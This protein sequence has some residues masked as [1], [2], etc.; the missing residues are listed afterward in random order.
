MQRKIDSKAGKRFYSPKYAS[1][2]S[3]WQ[4]ECLK[5]NWKDPVF[6]SA[7]MEYEKRKKLL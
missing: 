4:L 3:D 5:G 7:L 2:V 6:L 1:S